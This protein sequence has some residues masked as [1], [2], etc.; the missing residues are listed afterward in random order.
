MKKKIFLKKNTT[1]CDN[2]LWTKMGLKNCLKKKEI[3]GKSRLAGNQKE[4]PL[5]VCLHPLRE[6]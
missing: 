1:K 4:A 6:G 2:L 3:K 5:E